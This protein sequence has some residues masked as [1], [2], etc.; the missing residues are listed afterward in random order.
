MDAE[1]HGC[2]LVR[3]ILPS[4]FER[5]LYSRMMTDRNVTTE[6]FNV[7]PTH[8]SGET[9]TTLI[10]IPCTFDRRVPYGKSLFLYST[11]YPGRQ[12][13]ETTEIPTYPG[14]P[15]AA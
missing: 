4:D 1:E 12:E 9:I 3:F 14:D 7:V 10:G 6:D 13:S 15:G 2:S 11:G 8:K 5:Y